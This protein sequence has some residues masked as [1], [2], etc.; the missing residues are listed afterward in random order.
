MYAIRSY[1][2]EIAYRIPY[3]AEIQL[4]LGDLNY[5]NGNYSAA[6][7]NFD[8]V[9]EYGFIDQGLIFKTLVKRGESYYRSGNYISAEKDF[10]EVTK[11]KTRDTN[12]YLLLSA[13]YIKQS[14]FDEAL[15][16]LKIADK[17]APDEP[18]VRNNFV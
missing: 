8:A 16:T 2:G 13:I 17:I 1:Y 10:V 15:N 4:I 12:T 7:E 18:S 5:K 9:I 6:A 14:K 3:Y 11:S